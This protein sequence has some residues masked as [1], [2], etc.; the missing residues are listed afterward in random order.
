M[1][2]MKQ[3]WAML[4]GTHSTQQK[5]ID[6]FETELEKMDKKSSMN[7]SLLAYDAL[8]LW[9]LDETHQSAIIQYI[10]EKKLL[11][12]WEVNMLMTSVNQHKEQTKENTADTQ[13]KVSNIL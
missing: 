1:G 6:F 11:N 2:I 7:I 9:W 8:T 5:T 4:T 3:I 10:K 12:P 13:N